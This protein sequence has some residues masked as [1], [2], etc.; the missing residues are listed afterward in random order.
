MSLPG[1]DARV[2]EL[3][4]PGL[5]GISGEHLLD[6]VAAVTVAG[7]ETG[8]V[9]RPADRLRRPAPGPVLQALGRA[10][11]RTLEG[12]LW[13]KMTSGGAAKA[14]W[15]LLFPFS[16]ANVAHGMLPPV[17][18]RSKTA[19]VLGG[20]CRGL[21]RVVGV[22]LTALF[23]S[24]LGVISLDLVAAKCLAPD[25]ACLS[26]VPAW[27]RQWELVRTAV[28]LIPL[29]VVIV[30]LYRV[31]TATRVTGKDRVGVEEAAVD[32]LELG[33]LPG[34]TLILSP[35]SRVLRGLHTIT[36][37]GCVALLPL[38]GPFVVP[39]GT[40]SRVVWGCAIGL[41]ALSVLVAALLDDR[42]HWLRAVFSPLLSRLLITAG[43]ALV[44]AAAWLRSPLP[45][46][47]VGGRTPLAG[48]D[49]MVEGIGAALFFAC[50]AF[51]VLLIP[52]ALLARKVW[53]SLPRRLR[54]WLGGWAAAPT[55]ILAALLGGGFGAGLA[56]SVR[57]LLGRP[58]FLLPRSY[59]ALTSLWGA[60]TIIAAALWLIT[61]QLAVPLRTRLRGIPQIVRMLHGTRA[62]AE[63]AAAAW[64]KAIIERK[65]L[66]RLVAT[67]AILLALGAVGLVTLRLTDRRPP[68][69]V[70]PLE[71]LGVLALGL[72][73]AG[74]LRVV[75]TAAKSPERSRHL[76][77][78]ADLVY[79][80]PRRAHPV[81]PPSYALKVV[82][83]LAERARH[84][85]REPNTRVVLSGYSHGGLLAV[86]A[87]A[88]LI[89]ALNSE[90]RERVGLLTAGTP[91]QWGYQRA[92]P[93]LMPHASLANLYGA[94]DGRWRG[95]CRGTDP[96][97]G[98][99]TTWRHQ[100]VGGKL[101]GV[102]YLPDG[103]VG[104]L[105][106][107]IAGP[108]GALVLGGDH[109]LPDP[110]P[111]RENGRRWA[112]GVLKHSDYLV[113][114]E[115]DRAVAMAAGLER[116]DAPT[117]PHGEQPTLFGDSPAVKP[118]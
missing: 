113:D 44:L 2:V 65:H 48:V 90:Q 89:L 76:G 97:G 86:I 1:P 6:A 94:L 30:V 106:V 32:G 25:S 80:W 3:R 109:W 17:P 87:T 53:R 101:L 77:A 91:L 69:W 61:Y 43:A 55:V 40:S 57:Q 11:P 78:L 9:I 56:I 60:G 20:M 108:A 51:S 26:A 75:Y 23:I 82:P 93:N 21:L 117:R 27:A 102:G 58:E 22:L 42:V 12:Y 47:L 38:G 116:P 8:E 71:T 95:L 100:V 67:V 66:H 34:E 39:T 46:T 81:V 83:D 63:Q 37:L 29:L 24:Q 5:V 85:L 84:H 111:L 99:V 103:S 4:V 114:P 36:A 64:A 72:L 59:D 74:L 13:H 96:F 88:R 31:S 79:F 41:I 92:F 14:T 10:L 98:G 49:G 105:P 104:P 19:T 62:E 35:A 33:P 110:V 18:E 68:E 45:P 52:A 16:L 115:W 70:E 73:A 28:G 107:A 112:A 54:P 118:R 15:A 50:A 7:D